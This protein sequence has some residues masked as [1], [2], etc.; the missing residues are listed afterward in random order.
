MIKSKKNVIYISLLFLSGLFFHSCRRE[1]LEP[2]ERG[3][4]YYPF[5]EGLWWEYDVDSTY[6]DD[7]SGD[8]T[9]VSFIL[10]EEFDSFFVATDGQLAI[11]IKRYR[12]VNES[13]P[14]QGP[15]IWWTYKTTESAVKVEENNAYIKLNF[16]VSSQKEWNGNGLNFMDAWNYTYENV[17]VPYTVNGNVFD[18]TTS[19]LQVDFETLLE[20][21]FYQEKYARNVGLIEKTVT[22]VNGYTDS[23]NIPDTIAK[24]ILN[25][26]KS[27]L[28]IRQR[29]RDWGS[30]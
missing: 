4:N 10:R 24:P 6:Y 17:D 26:I 12:R 25:R 9:Q 5:A 14:W 19:I 27:G 16:P 28:V 21:Q 29:I 30:L 8:T 22:D 1:V 15:R 20:K 7:F 23:D 2:S 13:S 11:L 3:E 18:S